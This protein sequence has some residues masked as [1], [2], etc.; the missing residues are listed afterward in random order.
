MYLVPTGDKLGTELG[1]DFS[2]KT[3][4]LSIGYFAYEPLPNMVFSTPLPLSSIVSVM[5]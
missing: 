5:C 1:T 3:I 4:G 2:L